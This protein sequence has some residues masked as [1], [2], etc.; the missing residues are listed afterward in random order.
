MADQHQHTARLIAPR[1]SLAQCIRAH[2]AR[3]TAGLVLAAP[4]RRNHFPATA[5][6]CITWFIQGSAVRLADP[7]PL[8]HEVVFRGPHTVPISSYNPGPVQTYMLL[9]MPDALHAMTGIDAGRHLNRICAAHKVFDHTWQPMLRAVQTARDDAARVLL[10]EDFLEPRWRA[11]WAARK[12]PWGS[13]RRYTEWVGS[14]ATHAA[15][16]GPGRGARQIERRVRAWAGLPMRTLRG[17]S[18]AERSFLF[19]LD[20]IAARPYQDWSWADVAMEAGYADQP[21]LCRE[22]RRFTG[23]SPQQLLQGLQRDEAFWVYRAWS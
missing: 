20:C 17:L 9:L 1:E 19:V 5:S 16:T 21:H 13:A 14:L 4:Q 2:L 12:T 7:Q 23:F 18:R 8:P 11:V 6:C 22:V 10:V 15:L 3:S